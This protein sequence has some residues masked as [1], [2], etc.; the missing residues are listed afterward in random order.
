[1]PWQNQYRLSGLSGHRKQIAAMLL[2]GIVMALSSR[3]IIQNGNDC[4]YARLL[5]FLLAI[6]FPIVDADRL[7]IT[8]PWACLSPI[9]LLGVYVCGLPAYWF[10]PIPIAMSLVHKSFVSGVRQL[11]ID[12]KDSVFDWFREPDDFATTQTVGMPLSSV[13]LMYPIQ[14]LYRTVFRCCLKEMLSG[15]AVINDFS[16][17]RGPFRP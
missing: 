11:L 1:M 6:V 15:L 2:F 10:V 5:A 13:A 7:R 17:S 3:Y 14:K 4:S 16:A 12:L 8:P 9:V